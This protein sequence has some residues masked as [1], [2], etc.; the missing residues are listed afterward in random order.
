MAYQRFKIKLLTTGSMRVDTDT[1]VQI[2]IQRGIA[3]VYYMADLKD[4]VDV[5]KLNFKELNDWIEQT[6]DNYAK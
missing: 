5:S 3:S 2:Y 4:E 6:I 1:K